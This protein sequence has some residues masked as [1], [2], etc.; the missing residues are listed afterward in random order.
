MH[1]RGTATDDARR[2]PYKLNDTYLASNFVRETV[3]DASLL[4]YL[5]DL[6]EGGPIVCPIL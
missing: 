1:F 2:F 6:L 3:L 5:E 4:G